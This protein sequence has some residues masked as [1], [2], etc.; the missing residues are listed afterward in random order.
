MESQHSNSKYELSILNIA[1]MNAD[2]DQYVHDMN[3]LIH[4]KFV[5]ETPTIFILYIIFELFK[6]IY[7]LAYYEIK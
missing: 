2:F 7:K 6:I 5:S 3:E 4:G 1:C